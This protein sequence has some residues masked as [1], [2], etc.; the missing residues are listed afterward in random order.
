[1]GSGWF[2]LATL[3]KISQ[4]LCIEKKILRGNVWPFGAF[5]PSGAVSCGTVQ[6]AF[7][8]PVNGTVNVLE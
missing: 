7:P 4:K 6:L 8:P 5:P 3:G 2:F 1:M